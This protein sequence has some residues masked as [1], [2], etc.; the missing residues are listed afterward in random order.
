[1]TGD[2]ALLGKS[3]GK[4]AQ[5]EKATF[6]TLYGLEPAREEAAIAARSAV[7]A[8]DQIEGDHDFL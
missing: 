6:V 7:T 2:P 8:L 1:M 4:D 3:V 5:A